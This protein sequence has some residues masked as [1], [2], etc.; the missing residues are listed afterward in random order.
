MTIAFSI[1][2][3]DDAE[4][5]LAGWRDLYAR[6][7]K[8]T[9]FQS[10]AWIETWLRQAEDRA[11][12]HAIRATEDGT[13]LLLGIIGVSQSGLVPFVSLRE[14]RLGETAREAIDSVYVEYNDF[15]QAAGGPSDLGAEAWCA[16]FDH[17]PGIDSFVV[18]NGT[19]SCVSGL[20]E[21]ALA[22]GMTVRVLREEHSWICRLADLRQTSSTVLSSLSSNSR[23]QIERC[24]KLYEE[25][26]EVALHTPTGDDQWSVSWQRLETLH[27]ATWEARGG[28]SVFANPDL[29]AFHKRLRKDHPESVALVELRA[30]EETVGVLYNF[31]H[32][33]RVMN[34]QSGFQ[35]EEDNRLKPGLLTHV[36]AAQHYL[37]NGLDTYDM[38]VGDVRYKQSLG[39]AGER[40]SLVEAVRPGWRQT[41]VSLARSL[42]YRIRHR[43]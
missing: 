26:G 27:A 13:T 5:F 34:Y 37:D 16:V 14:A 19:V 18:R 25:R 4:A 41:A 3:L 43:S 24:A 40:M 22:R 15:L 36:M 9:F 38:L 23:K 42:R 21:A 33:G 7:G 6:A 11:E 17:F 12:L 35:Y 31:V 29:L 10:P 2:P 39:E 30:G 32:E 8:K 28:A 20:S 1:T